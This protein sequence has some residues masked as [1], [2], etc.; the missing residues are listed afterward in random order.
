MAK[1]G[2]NCKGHHMTTTEYI[3]DCFTNT[4]KK[5]SVEEYLTSSA[6]LTL[7]DQKDKKETMKKKRAQF[8]EVST[9]VEYDYEDPTYERTKSYTPSER[10]V[11]Q[12]DSI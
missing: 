6:L 7:G 10:K 3:V 2:N 8:S 4:A 1:A 12:V 5:K 11:F 9:L